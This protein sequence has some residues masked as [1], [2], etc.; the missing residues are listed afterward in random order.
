M[1]RIDVP[2]EELD[3]LELL[4]ADDPRQRARLEAVRARVSS[5]LQHMAEAVA[6]R[7]DKG[8]DAARQLV[9]TDRDKTEMDALRAA[10][11]PKAARGE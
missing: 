1:L 6:L 7:T 9:L 8:F 5:H 10:E 11:P 4:T 2:Y 3:R